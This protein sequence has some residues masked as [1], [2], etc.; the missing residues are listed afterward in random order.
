MISKWMRSVSKILQVPGRQA[1][2]AASSNKAPSVSGPRPSRTWIGH[3][4]QQYNNCKIRRCFS[5]FLPNVFI[6]I[7]LHQMFDDL[8]FVFR[9]LQGVVL[10]GNLSRAGNPSAFRRYERV[11]SAE[12]LTSGS[13]MVK[14]NLASFSFSSW[15]AETKLWVYRM[16]H[17]V[18]LSPSGHLHLGTHS[19]S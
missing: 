1:Q 6:Y 16:N 14:P 13:A 9:W 19:P 3:G 11:Q 18:I 5:I 7:N 2:Y 12:K 4:Q 15:G 17:W 10:H 8:S